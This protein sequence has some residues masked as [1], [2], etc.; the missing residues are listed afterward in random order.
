MAA[1]GDTLYTFGGKAPSGSLPQDMHSFNTALGSWTQVATTGPYPPGRAHHTISAVVVPGGSSRTNSS[2]SG[3]GTLYV[4]MLFP[5]A[6]PSA[7]S[8]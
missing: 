5:L 2:L 4:F 7:V 8:D 1:L 6:Q 3:G